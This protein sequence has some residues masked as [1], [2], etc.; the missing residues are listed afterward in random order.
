MVGEPLIRRCRSRCGLLRR[1][2]VVLPY[3]A[4][5][6]YVGEEKGTRRFERII[7]CFYSRIDF[8]DVEEIPQF[9][10]HSFFV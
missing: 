1:S 4:I 6:K 9:D 7:F 10:C 3:F 8:D 5:Q 2:P